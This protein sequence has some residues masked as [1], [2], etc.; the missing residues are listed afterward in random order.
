M[1]PNSLAELWY[2]LWKLITQFSCLSGSQSLSPKLI[3]HINEYFTFDAQ[4]KTTKAKKNITRLEHLSI[5]SCIFV[6]DGLYRP[7]YRPSIAISAGKLHIIMIIMKTAGAFTIRIKV[8]TKVQ[9]AMRVFVWSLR[10]CKIIIYA[11]NI[12]CPWLVRVRPIDN[13]T[14]I[15]ENPNFFEADRAQVCT[16]YD[17]MPF[18]IHA[19]ISFSVAGAINALDS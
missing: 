18:C 11:I 4:H 2:F 17:P 19:A 3:D 13:S 5:G 9:C 16:V 6:A 7:P 12:T 10:F 1:S 15:S 14:E 8:P